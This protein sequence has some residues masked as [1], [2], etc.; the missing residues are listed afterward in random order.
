MVLPKDFKDKFGTHPEHKGKPKCSYSMCNAYNSEEYRDDMYLKYFLG[1]DVPSGDFA[2]FGTS[3][4]EY[5]EYKA[6][7]EE[8]LGHLSEE[9][10]KILDSK[11]E[12][13]DN[14]VYEDEIVIDFG[15]FVLEGYT[16]RTHYDFNNVV[17][18]RD[19]KTL[20]IPKKVS[21][22]ESDEYLQTV[23]YA[24][25]KEKEGFKI[26]DVEVFGLG[27]K[28]S[29]LEGNGNFKMRLSGETKVIP[30]PYTKERA[31]KAVKFIKDTVKKIEKDYLIY[32][33]YFE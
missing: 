12:Y 1:I 26:G 17:H 31:K 20:N 32:R 3:C 11:I 10:V 33:K 25:Q 18:I 13:P 30:T 27:R 2:E 14:C 23:L 21:Y 16:D 28:G 6:K 29:S 7:G 9:D 22:Y 4:G 8:R 15:E 24:Y 19:Y 5:I